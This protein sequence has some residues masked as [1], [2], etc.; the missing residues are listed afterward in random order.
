MVN[1]NEDEIH[2]WFAYDREI[3]DPQLL[4]EYSAV[5][6]NQESSRQARFYFEKDR[7][8]YLVTRA[9]VRSTLSLYINDIEPAQWEFN[10]NAYGKPA[11][12]NPTDF[13][14]QFNLSHTHGMI[15]MAVTTTR[16]VGVDVEWLLR[17]GETVAIADNFFSPQEVKQLRSLPTAEQDSRFFDLWTLK[18]SY[19]KAYGMGLSIPLDQFSFSFL[20]DDRISI[21]F[22]PRWNDHPDNWFFWQIQPRDTHKVALAVESKGKSVECCRLSFREVTPMRQFSEVSYPNF[23]GWEE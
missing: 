8:Q 9:L 14:L 4:A 6:N 20:K 16:K 23:P 18:E 1:I 17:G 19:I 22:D 11:I 2:L 13:P 7:H 15:V 3:S 21:A 10:K 5:L 12:G